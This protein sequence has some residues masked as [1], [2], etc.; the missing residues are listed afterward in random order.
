MPYY[1]HQFLINKRPLIKL[2]HFV[3]CSFPQE[4]HEIYL[5]CQWHL[6]LKLYS[7]M[8]WVRKK[9]EQKNS[10]DFINLL[11]FSLLAF[12]WDIFI[13]KT[14]LFSPTI[15]NFKCLTWFPFRV[16][17]FL[18]I[19]ISFMQSFKPYAWEVKF[20]TSVLLIIV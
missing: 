7:L 2:N 3:E 14:F 12:F 16:W 13:R 18:I 9:N 6:F 20:P 4:E 8:N 1:D 10:F 11:G 17:A 19:I 15:F 5:S